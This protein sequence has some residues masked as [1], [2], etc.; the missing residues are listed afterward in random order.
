MTLSELYLPLL[1]QAAGS[2]GRD[3]GDDTAGDFFQTYGKFV[4]TLG[5]AVS[6]LQGGFSLKRPERLFDIENK[7]SATGSWAKIASR[8][9]CIEQGLHALRARERR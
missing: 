5:E 6:T 7:A 9:D 2:W 3:M 4:D 8:E 1:R